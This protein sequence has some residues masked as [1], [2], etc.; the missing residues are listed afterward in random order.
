[1]RRFALQDHAEKRPGE[2]SGGQQ[3]RVA[4]A[5][6][7]AHRPRLLLLDEPTSALD[8]EMTAE[9]LAV[10]RQ[11][12]EEGQEIV[13]STHEMGFARAVADHVLFLAEGRL[14]E[15]GPAGELFDGT[16]TEEARRFL[17]KVMA[18]R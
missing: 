8:P 12:R 18:Y 16:R 9:V 5:R 13:L 11:L 14:V 3:Q 2:M 10:I 15:E 4:I 17:S 7:M 1:L 6:A